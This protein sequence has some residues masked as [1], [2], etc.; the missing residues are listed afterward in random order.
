MHYFQYKFSSP[1][2][3]NF[4][5][6]TLVLSDIHEKLVLYVFS[7]STSETAKLLLENFEF[8][9]NDVLDVARKSRENTREKTKEKYSTTTKAV[10]ST[11]ITYTITHLSGSTRI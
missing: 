11:K 10:K 1:S 3:N 6:Y 2:G 9:R 4:R 7:T 5:T 8:Y